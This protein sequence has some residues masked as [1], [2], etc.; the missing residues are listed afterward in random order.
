[1]NWGG[2][3]AWVG[4]VGGSGGRERGWVRFAAGWCSDQPAAASA[5]HRAPPTPSSIPH[6]STPAPLPAP[7]EVGELLAGKP[8]F[9][10]LEFSEEMLSD[11][12]DL[13]E[14]RRLHPHV[15]FKAVD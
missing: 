7:A 3:V 1:M 4:W 15:N 12:R 13:R 11:P 9:R 5:P 8:R 10:K 6:Q 2:I 14:L